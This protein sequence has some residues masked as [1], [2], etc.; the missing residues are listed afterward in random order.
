MRSAATCAT[1]EPA[2]C[3]QRRPEPR[4]DR[5]DA[6]G[7]PSPTRPATRRSG[8]APRRWLRTGLS[9][10]TSRR[11]TEPGGAA[12]RRLQFWTRCRHCHRRH[13]GCACCR[14]SIPPCATG[15]GPSGCSAFTTG[16]RSSCPHSSAAMAITCSRSC[17]AT[18]SSGGLTQSATACGCACR[19]A[20]ARA[21]TPRSPRSTARRAGPTGGR[22]GA[23]P[24]RPVGRHQT[25]SPH[26]GLAVPPEDRRRGARSPCRHG[27]PSEQASGDDLFAQGTRPTGP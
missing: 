12:S 25:H 2:T 24:R 5:S 11:Q 18:G 7:G 26:A 17:R 3:W 15:R 13:S 10:W 4:T 6:A 8:G 16:S 19:S 9:R 22:R 14:P 21:S 1:C 27:D 23:G 20:A